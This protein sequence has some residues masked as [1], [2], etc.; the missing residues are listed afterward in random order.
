[1]AY[2]NFYENSFV[3]LTQAKFF[4][5]NMTEIA[6]AIFIREARNLIPEG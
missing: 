6:R 4:S 5:L 1:M 3:H 2:L